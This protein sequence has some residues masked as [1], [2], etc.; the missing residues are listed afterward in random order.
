[1]QVGHRS[2]HAGPVAWRLS[3]THVTP[4]LLVALFVDLLADLAKFGPLA[5]N[6]IEDHELCQQILAVIHS[7]TKKDQI[8][9]VCHRKVLAARHLS[10]DLRLAL[11]PLPAHVLGG[12][13]VHVRGAHLHP[14]VDPLQGHHA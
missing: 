13:L 1:M 3:W 7:T 12:E 4:V 9:A 5:Q 2:G 14:R 11:D 8:F 10:R 6:R